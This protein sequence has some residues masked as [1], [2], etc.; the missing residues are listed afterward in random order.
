[1]VFTD[2]N[3]KLLASLTEKKNF[4]VD[5][6]LQKPDAPEVPGLQMKRIDIFP[7]LSTSLFYKH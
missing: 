7:W 5:S 1:M 3:E 2:S 4:K 6:H